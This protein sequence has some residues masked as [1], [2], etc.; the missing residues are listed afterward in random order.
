MPLEVFD[1]DD[2]RWPQMIQRARADIFYEPCYC[3][4]VTVDT[5]H[6]PVMLAYQ[7]DLGEVFDVTLRKNIADLPF[8]ADVAH[9]FARSPTDLASPEYNS[10]IVIAEPGAVGE[11]L[12]RYRRAVDEYCLESGVVTEFV[13]FHPLS[14]SATAF[15]DLL[16]L[17]QAAEMVYVDLR[18]G[19]DSAFCGYREN[20]KR[21]IKKALKQ[22][23]MFRFCPSRDEEATSLLHKLWSEA[24]LRKDAKSIYHHPLEHFVGFVQ[25]LGDRALI[26]ESLVD[27]DVA[28]V[29]VFVLGRKHIWH[30][31]S[32]L[33][34][35]FRVTGAH[36]F[37]F[38]R[39]I[40]WAWQAGYEYFMLGG[41]MEQGDST[42]QYKYG[43]S[44]LAAPVRHFKKVHD[45]KAL[46]LL[47]EAKSAYNTRL[48]LETK[49]QYFP[50]YWL[51]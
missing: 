10:P 47:L 49:Q 13:R 43:F 17:H 44:H 2:A 46:N 14:E 41:G 36:T 21:N 37:A 28:S 34:Q 4:F 18:R 45:Q 11:L 42:Y 51:A 6:Q 15:A 7:D 23:A 40:H 38:D 9:Q 35:R 19:Y 16:D 27:N 3:R 33:D 22:G 8:Y 1:L 39:T 24:M 50:S 12:R 31:Y 48:G 29:D 30:K 25:A 26:V 5:S 32:G 20:H